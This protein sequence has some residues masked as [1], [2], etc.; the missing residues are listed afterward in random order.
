MS[1]VEMKLEDAIRE[2]EDDESY[3]EDGCDGSYFSGAEKSSDGAK[4]SIE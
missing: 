1:Q 2:S 4:E 3:Q